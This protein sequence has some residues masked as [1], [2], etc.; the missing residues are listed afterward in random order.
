MEKVMQ[1]ELD[2]LKKREMQLLACLQKD[3]D[4]LLGEK[5]FL[6]KVIYTYICLYMLRFILPLW[7]L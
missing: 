3:K 7:F 2:E 6:E 5:S 4:K 1:Q